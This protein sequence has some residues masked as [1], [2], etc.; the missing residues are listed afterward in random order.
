VDQGKLHRELGVRLDLPPV[1]LQGIEP[2][3]ASSTG[4]VKVTF[5]LTG[6]TFAFESRLGPTKGKATI[7]VDGTKVDSIDLWRPRRRAPRRYP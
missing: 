2:Q 6:R 5:S 1:A 3:A 7:Y 4:E